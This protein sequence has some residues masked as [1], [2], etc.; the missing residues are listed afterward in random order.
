MSSCPN[1]SCGERLNRLIVA[2]AL[3]G[4]VFFHAPSLW[5]M[6]LA[7]LLLVS[8]LLGKCGTVALLK[9]FRQS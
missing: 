4:G 7:G 8:G 2:G 5:Y 1:I 3:L 6:V 9:Q